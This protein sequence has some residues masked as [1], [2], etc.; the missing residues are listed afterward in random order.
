MELFHNEIE[1][2]KSNLIENAYPPFL[3][4][5]VIKIYLDHKF[6]SNQNQLKDTSNVCYFKLPY[7]GNFLHNI[8]NELEHATKPFNSHYSSRFSFCFF[9]SLFFSFFFYLLF[10]LFLTL[11]IGIFYCLNYITIL[12]HLITAPMVSHLYLLSMIFILSGTNYQHLLL[13]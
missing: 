9:L 2:I 3:I 12:L 5:K 11:V 13:S 7:I 8:R 10:S 4:D 1:N 6:S